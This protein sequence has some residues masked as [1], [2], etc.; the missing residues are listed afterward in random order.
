MSD[1]SFL[2]SLESV[3]NIASPPS[4]SFNTPQQSPQL[5]PNSDSDDIF[6][7]YKSNK[8]NVKRR[9]G[10]RQK[11]EEIPEESEEEEQE[12]EEEKS[13]AEEARASRAL[14]PRKQMNYFKA[15]YDSEFESDNVSDYMDKATKKRK[16]SRSTGTR[17][18][19][20]RQPKSTELD[21]EDIYVDENDQRAEAIAEALDKI[22]KNKKQL[23]KLYEKV[24]DRLSF[25]R[26]K[27]IQEQKELDCK[28]RNLT[29]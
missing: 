8:V 23:Q 14:R 6:T 11:K 10:R 18:T 19:E 21:E 9:R 1:D 3:D 7:D 28:K 22:P 25:Y 13:E 26:S 15:E 4:H 20:P 16:K 12:Q 24:Q 17:G 27:F 29:S 5:L 2:S